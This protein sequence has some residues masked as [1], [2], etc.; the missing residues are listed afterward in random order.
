M[1]GTLRSWIH[2]VMLRSTPGTQKEHMNIAVLCAHAL[3]TVFPGMKGFI[4]FENEA[5]GK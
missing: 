1:A 3:E 4:H 2:Y 5:Y